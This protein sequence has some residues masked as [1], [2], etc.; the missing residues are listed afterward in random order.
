MTAKARTT[1]T[2]ATALVMMVLVALAIAHFITRH[3]V[4]TDNTRVVTIAI[5]FF[6]A[7]T[8]APLSPTSRRCY[9]PLLPSPLPSL[10]PL[11]TPSLMLPPLLLLLSPSPLLL[12]PPPLSLM[13][14]TLLPL[15][16]R[17]LSPLPSLA[18]HPRCRSHGFFCHHQYHRRL[19]AVSKR[20]AMATTTAMAALRATALGNCGGGSSDEDGCHDSGGK[21]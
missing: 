15:Q 5:T 18:H 14:A 9:C 17:M 4:A 1:A 16:L 21:D 6:A 19:I 13:P 20:L 8:I 2:A 11:S 7:L 3:I 10:L 12:P